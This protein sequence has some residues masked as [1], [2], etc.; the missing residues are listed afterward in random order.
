MPKKLIPLPKLKKKAWST[1]KADKE[2]SKWI[3]ARDGK[4]LRCGTIE[5]LTNSHFWTRKNSAL[6]YEPDNCITLCAWKCH[7]YGWEKEKQ[8]AYRDFMI[9]RL[10]MERYEELRKIFYQSKMTRREA[11]QRCRELLYSMYEDRK[12]ESATGL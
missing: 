2:F 1:D 7:I 9:E 11:I 3:R 5:N 6:R 8:G 10:G 4:C 12:S